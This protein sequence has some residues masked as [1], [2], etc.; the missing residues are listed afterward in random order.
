[1]CNL[2]NFIEKKN[3]TELLVYQSAIESFEFHLQCK[4]RRTVLWMMDELTALSSKNK[5]HQEQNKTKT[6]SFFLFSQQHM[7]QSLTC[8][9]LLCS[10]VFH[11]NSCF[12]SWV[13][14]LAHSQLS[15]Q[16]F[17]TLFIQFRKQK[18]G[19]STI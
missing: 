13:L 8:I 4:K 1:M 11:C 18:K 6:P 15:P 17:F 7:N 19:K 14:Q 10:S 16:P 9:K 5:K 2:F 3:I 12:F